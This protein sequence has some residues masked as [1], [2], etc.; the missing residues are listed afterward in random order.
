MNKGIGSILFPKNGLKKITDKNYKN[1]LRSNDYE[2]CTAVARCLPNILDVMVLENIKLSSYKI[3]RLPS[4]S[5]EKDMDFCH[6]SLMYVVSSVYFNCTLI[7]HVH[8]LNSVS[9]R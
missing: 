3:G 9:F 5:N 8:G 7:S 1:H 2:V 6:Q 4:W